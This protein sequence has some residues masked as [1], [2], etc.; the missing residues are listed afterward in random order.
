MLQILDPSFF[1]SFHLR[2]T[3]GMEVEKA[4]QEPYVMA[5]ET[6]H[7]TRLLSLDYRTDT[8]PTDRQ[9]IAEMET[10]PMLSA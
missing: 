10:V 4:M 9:D 3:I 1:R 8:M 7:I 2:A 6:R 5:P